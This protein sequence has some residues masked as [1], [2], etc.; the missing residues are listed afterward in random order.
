MGCRDIWCPIIGAL[1]AES[2]S[3]WPNNQNSEKRKKKPIFLF[4]KVSVLLAL[5]NGCE[6]SDLKIALPINSVFLHWE[7]GQVE[8]GTWAAQIGVWTYL[9]TTQYL[10]NSTLVHTTSVT[11][12][13]YTLPQ[14]YFYWTFAPGGQRCTSP[15]S[16]Y[17]HFPGPD[18]GS[19]GVDD[20]LGI[21]TLIPFSCTVRVSSTSTLS[22]GFS[23]YSLSTWIFIVLLPLSFCLL[24]STLAR[25]RFTFFTWSMSNLSDRLEWGD[26]AEKFGSF[27]C[28]WLGTNLDFLGHMAAHL[29]K[30]AAPPS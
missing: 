7:V 9:W 27:L 1:R 21:A 30:L 23:E 22:I 26:S 10:S 20:C 3:V 12:P 5:R 17:T 2:W 24:L 8:V 14:L 19:W 15:G 4:G 16:S 11:Q 13:Q 29:C 18:W 28:M 6:A 25:C